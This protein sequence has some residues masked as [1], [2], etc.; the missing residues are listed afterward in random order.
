MDSKMPAFITKL[1]VSRRKKVMS[2][3]LVWKEEVEVVD[4]IVDWL[5][6]KVDK[7][8]EEDEKEVITE[9]EVKA[10]LLQNLAKRAQI[11][12]VLKIFK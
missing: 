12:E 1:P 3:Y 7:M 10:R 11:R 9:F 6:D 2:Q 4:A 8:I 5:E